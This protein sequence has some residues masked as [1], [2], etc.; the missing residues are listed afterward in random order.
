ML[1]SHCHL[2]HPDFAEDAAASVER[3][4]DAGVR[5]MVTVGYDLDSSTRAVEIASRHREVWAAVGVHPHEARTYD[6]AAED[7][8]REL[9]RHP[10]VVAIG[11]IG[12]DY[13]YD[14]SPR[15]AQRAAF[16]RQLELADETDLPVI[17][18]CRE[19]HDD[20][21]ELVERRPPQRRGVMHCWSGS[22]AEA[23]RAVELGLLVGVAGVITFKKRGQL[24]DVVRDVPPETLL[25]ETDA[26]YLAPVPWRGKR[27]EPSYLPHVIERLAQ[28]LG[29]GAAETARLTED[30]ARTLFYRLGL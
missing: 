27:N 25:A 3:A 29:Y 21:L 17:I 16:R 14:F 15:N 9:A 10:R 2:N 1:D 28:D 11:E 4:V 6:Q 24:A 26:P 19:A 18:H 5:C 7:R 22:V 23:H 30:N 20:A 8:L 12:L 13:H